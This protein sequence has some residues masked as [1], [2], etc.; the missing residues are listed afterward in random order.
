[1]S[2]LDFL[3]GKGGLK[4]AVASAW[5]EPAKTL[6]ERLGAAE[7]VR[8]VG[9]GDAFPL[10]G[11]DKAWLV[12]GGH[13]DLFMLRNLDPGQDPVTGGTR[14][15]ATTVEPG[16]LVFGLPEDAAA[17][18]LLA[19]PSANTSIVE[20]ERG[21][22]LDILRADATPG[23]E[24]DE[25]ARLR[26]HALAVSVRR[27]FTLF[28]GLEP[29]SATAVTV[30]GDVA[31]APGQPVVTGQRM[32]W[33]DAGERTWRINDMFDLPAPPA[34]VSL[35][36]CHGV[37]LTP[38]EEGSAP[39][40]DTVT[41]LAR[42]QVAVD[43]ELAQRIAL[44]A[45][46]RKAARDESDERARAERR[47]QTEDHGFHLSLFGLLAVVRPGKGEQA[48]VERSPLGAA[49]ARVM[50]AHGASFDVTPE[51]E[52]HLLEHADPLGSLASA[53][54]LQPRRV[55]LTGSWWQA[56][57]GPLVGFR[58]EERQPFALLPE[59]GGGY[60]AI[61][62]LGNET[63]LERA[64]A[65]AGFGSDAW[66]LFPPFPSGKL[67]AR[68]IAGFG[69]CGMKADLWLI[70]ALVVMGGLL[71]LATPLLTGWI[72]DPV[73]P[74]AE[75]GQLYVLTAALVIAG[76]ATAGFGLTQSLA[77]LRVEGTMD[78]RVQAAVW[79]RLLKLEAGFFRGYSVGDLANRAQ[80]INGMR[81]IMTGSVTSSLIHG[82]IG[83]FSL[84]LMLYYDWR[85]SACTVVIGAIYAVITYVVGRMVLSRYRETLAINGKLQSLVLQ[86][87]S[88]IAKIRIAGA[89]RSA[90]ARWSRHYSE[91]LRITFIQRN[92][93][94]RLVVF[95]TAFNTMAVAGVL[96]LIGLQGGAL[97]AAFHTAT[98]WNEIETHP[99]N[100]VMSTAN[101][102]S[103]NMAFGQFLGAVFGLTGIALQLVNIKPLYERVQPILDGDI[104][105][106]ED[107]D[108][109]GTITGH[110]EFR[111]VQFGYGADSPPVLK[112]VS[113]VAQP[114]EFV[115]LVGP[116]GAGKST[117]V[118]LL[119][120]FETPTA[121]SIF[122][123]GK[124][125]AHLDRRAV[126]RQFGVVL[127]AGRLLAG[128]I[129]HNIAAGAN[130]SRD[131]AWEA[132][133]RAGFAED[134][135]AM[136]MGMETFLNEGAG[137]L[138]GGQRQ[139]LMIAR[140]LVRKPRLVVFDEAT[141]ALDN[142]TQAIVSES[143]E[144]MNCTRIVIAHRLSTIMNADRIYV[145]QG[146]VIAEQG[147][148]RELMKAGGVFSQLARRQIA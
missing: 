82:V 66:F 98:T 93:N 84:G 135:E 134:I 33:I 37:W 105:S 137:T 22:L 8:V 4:E 69:L 119:L 40:L 112:G 132:A 120:G 92:L 51:R 68:R 101:F 114:G 50:A 20:V 41:W 148:Y 91:L 59:R 26:I 96:I 10:V 116:S 138:S 57:H 141:S 145:L 95:K 127:Q 131:D 136:P 130:V 81:K 65:A 48:T 54:G 17:P 144:A 43:L 75:I 29:Y 115:A 45:I 143:L 77:M 108:D 25:G 7:A 36:L 129:F 133:R 83:A 58:G 90:F 103:F 118:R 15:F 28:E 30:P 31:L 9:G 46:E 107:A 72:M 80:S 78:Y 18:Q 102:V 6:T 53:A 124:D 42:G 121:G 2:G 106:A 52:A 16:G 73:I 79:D 100:T 60:V 12:L 110:V 86:L 47:A 85:L 88:G 139:R 49:M 34:N 142:K 55:A 87:L 19:V 63:K 61:D 24:I 74:N 70:A 56:D 76:M 5:V 125:F 140:A 126:R 3:F 117:I 71:S 44:A 27:L 67:T 146:G 99:L 1:M 23:T 113:L 14:Y 89:E 21:A 122:I 62:E 97:F 38:E 64:A 35:P 32:F 109:P 104:E 13:L 123:D 11:R 147:T 94:N 128:S 39:A 111:G